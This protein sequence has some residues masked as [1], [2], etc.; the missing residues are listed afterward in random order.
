MYKAA[1]TVVLGAG[2]TALGCQHASHQGC[3][4][5][6]QLVAHQSMGPADRPLSSYSLPA[7]LRPPGA[8]RPDGRGE[9]RMRGP[10][11][12]SKIRKM[13]NLSKEDDVRK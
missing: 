10:K 4:G 6:A 8:A 7:R 9:P 5:H 2:C 1:R 3:T 12:A 13:F 11:R